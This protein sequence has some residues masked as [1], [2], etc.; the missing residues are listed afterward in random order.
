VAHSG[1]HSLPCTS[2]PTTGCT[3]DPIQHALSGLAA[4]PHSSTVRAG[5]GIGKSPISNSRTIKK[6]EQEHIKNKI[7]LTSTPPSPPT[8]PRTYFVS[9]PAAIQTI[10]HELN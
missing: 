10:Y 9:A 2:T 1:G 4:F 3:L 7:T 5:S 8:Q 6:R